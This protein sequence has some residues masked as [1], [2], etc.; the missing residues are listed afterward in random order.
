M[1]V[2]KKIVL[3]AAIVFVFMNCYSICLADE[4]IQ[5]LD[6]LDEYNEIA[7]SVEAENQTV[8]DE[9]LKEYYN[10][11]RDYLKGYYDSY[12][13]EEPILAVVTEISEVKESYE[14]SYDYSVA[15]YTY[16]TVKAKILD[17]AYKDKEADLEYLLTADALDNI[18][19]A[20]LHVGDKIFI[21]VT[22][23]EDGTITG[24]ISNSWATVLRINTILCIGVIVMLLAIIYAGRKG[25]SL[26]LISIIIL[27]A[28]IIIIP[29]FAQAGMGVVG[30]SVLISLLLIIAV[31]M[32]H[33]G[34]RANTLKSIGVSIVLSIFTLL[35]T[36]GM[37]YITRTVGT[38]FEY[39]AIAENVILGNIDF[40]SIFYMSILVIGAGVIANVVSMCISRIEKSG[41]DTYSDKVK[42][43]KD[44]LLSH[45]SILVL[46]LFI[47]YIPNHI[48]LLSNKFV[49]SEIANSETL[50]SEFIRLFAIVIPVILSIP[51]VS[52]DFLRIGETSETEDL[53][54]AL[55]EVEE[56]AEEEIEEA[57]EAVEEA[58]EK[59]EEKAEEIAEKV[60]EKV[61]EVK[62]AVEEKAEE[63]KE[64]VKEEVEET[65]EKVEEKAEE[66]EEA[67][68]EKVEEVKQNNKKG[69]KKKSKK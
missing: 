28:A 56:E 49:E 12:V 2:L 8:S 1:E 35:F 65:I 10:E 9:D 60:E 4:E 24:T 31:S 45:V 54:E 14:V 44:I 17:G 27:L 51:I 21:T 67:I 16:Q 68:E 66:V 61:E 64:E 25:L 55:E 30:T 29:L 34:L 5:V 50:I 15:K 37:N 26:S 57:E 40:T 41:A 38:T 18:K 20:E 42:E 23:N 46:A 59:A 62:E 53:V 36:F 58:E 6:S 13:R 43:C 47:T 32:A 11:Y 22:E 3:I 63:V 69:K 39:A 52:L 33:L 19:L 7:G 48:L